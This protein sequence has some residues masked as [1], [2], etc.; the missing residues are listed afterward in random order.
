M[1]LGTIVPGAR[2]RPHANGRQPP[3]A[4][5]YGFLSTH[6]PTRC[7]LATFNAALAA[8]LTTG[9]AGGGVVRV[10]SGG[11]EGPPGPDVTHT[12]QAHA[13]VNTCHLIPPICSLRARGGVCPEVT[14]WFIGG[15]L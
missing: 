13:T 2:A 1:P 3:V 12:W 7:G 9:P 6:P 10:T 11:N 14:A 8:A 15:P 4:T 5:T